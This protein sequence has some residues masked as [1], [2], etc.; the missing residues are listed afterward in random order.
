M[1]A[2]NLNLDRPVIYVLSD[3]IGETGELVVKAAASQF[4]SGTIDIRRIPYLTSSRDVE[5]ALQEVAGCQAAIV[6]TLVRQDLKEILELKARELGIVCVDIMSPI[7]AAIE[8]VTHTAPLFEPGLI[9]RMDDAYFLKVEAI[10]FA[11]KYDDG[12]QPWGLAKA[13]LV[14]IGVSRSSKTPLCMYLA[15]K[16]IKVANVPLV[17]E[18]PPPEELFALPSS[19]V[20][21]LTIKPALLYEIRKERLK[22]LG[23]S[24]SVDYAN[25]E[26]IYGEMDYA[27]NV[28]KKIRCEII[29]VSNKA[30]E[31]IAA[32]ILDYYQ[33]G[34]GK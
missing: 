6:Y 26:R 28:M 32:K 15:H 22:T 34:A 16:G 11:V 9:R 2:I 12:K 23:L 24:E 13:D 5:D 25:P 7:L 8:T 29:D 1:F 31:E 30:V 4:N 3:S 10:E 17:P 20:I 21:G 14:I 33:K 18:V 27:I 19:K